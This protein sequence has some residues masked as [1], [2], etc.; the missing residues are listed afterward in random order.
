MAY[1]KGVPGWNQKKKICRLNKRTRIDLSFFHYARIII[2]SCFLDFFFT[3]L[4][5]DSSSI[6]QRLIPYPPS[7][8]S[9]RVIYNS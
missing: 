6:N 1:R 2:H 3:V 7:N 8:K 4:D 9:L 5:T